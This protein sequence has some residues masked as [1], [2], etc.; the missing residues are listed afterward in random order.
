LQLQNF[1]VVRWTYANCF[2]SPAAW[3]KFRIW[4]TLTRQEPGSGVAEE[5]PHWLNRLLLSGLQ[6]EAALIRSG[7]RLPFGQ[8]FMVLARKP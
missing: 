4:E 2:L 3:F 7:F 8:S 1:S 5:L 6:F